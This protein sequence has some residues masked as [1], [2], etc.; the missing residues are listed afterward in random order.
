MNLQ[1]YYPVSIPEQIR[2][3]VNFH[4]QLAAACETVL[5]PGGDYEPIMAD[6]AYLIYLL[7]SWLGSIRSSAVAGTAFVEA[8]QM[9]SGAMD[10]P[11]WQEPPLP[12]GVVPVEA[13]ALR[14]IFAFVQRLKNTKGFTSVL[15][16][17]LS[18]H[19]RPA[20][21]KPAPGLQLTV[22]EGIDAEI[23]KVRF[24]KY[25]HQGVVIESRIGGQDAPWEEIGI[26]TAS[27]RFDKRPLRDPERPE[28][29]EYRLRFW[30]KGEA[31]G[32]WTVVSK[33]TVS[34]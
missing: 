18:L 23:V 25:G 15:A 20:V 1:E 3:L 32:D 22:G 7:G 8:M 19:P 31:N 4:A 17:G 14:R 28:V 12:A 5:I 30:D 11:A 21:E 27:P 2:W 34:P 16:S 24:F 33:I 6:A 29:R 10:R 26:T 13:G 9:G